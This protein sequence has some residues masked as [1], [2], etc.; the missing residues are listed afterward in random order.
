MIFSHDTNGNLTYL[1]STYYNPV[2]MLFQNI[3]R[4][5]KKLKLLLI[6]NPVILERCIQLLK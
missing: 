2:Q 3:N 1:R 4:V 6:N 5:R